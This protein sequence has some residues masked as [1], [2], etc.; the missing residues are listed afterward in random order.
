MELSDIL[1]KNNPAINSIM[2][3]ES[4]DA[5]AEGKVVEIQSSFCEKDTDFIAEVRAICEKKKSTQ[6]SFFESSDISD[7]QCEHIAQYA[8]IHSQANTFNSNSMVPYGRLKQRDNV[9]CCSC[10]CRKGSGDDLPLCMNE[11]NLT[12]LGP[13]VLLFFFYMKHMRLMVLLLLMGYS[14]YSIISSIYSPDVINFNT[15]SGKTAGVEKILCQ[16]NAIST[17]NLKTSPLLRHFQL[18]IG[19]FFFVIWKIGVRFIELLGEKKNE[20]ID[21]LLDSASDYTVR[22]ENLPFGKVS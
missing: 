7:D 22:I 12:F 14:F 9:H 13:G 6:K 1:L 10:G 2:E 15:C 20:E 11:Q 4:L 3:V 21:N 16:Y 19:M 18:W 8:R 17:F 5:M